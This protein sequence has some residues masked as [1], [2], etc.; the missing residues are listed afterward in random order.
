[1]IT[2][3]LVVAS[4]PSSTASPDR[5]KAVAD[6]DLA[7]DGRFVFAVTTTGIYCRPTCP[8]RRPRREHVEFFDRAADAE[9]AG[10]RACLRCKPKD[11][12]SPARARIE[13]ARAGLDGPEEEKPPP[14]GAP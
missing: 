12:V 3:N 10:F 8:S 1:M 9:Q 14:P 7:A 4:I 2:G 11:A 6:R 13:K 5:W